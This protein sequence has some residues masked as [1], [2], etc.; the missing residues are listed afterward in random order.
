[1]GATMQGI[2]IGKRIPI[3]AIVGGLMGFG[4]SMWNATHPDAQIS[5]GDAAGLTTATIG[6][7]QLLVVNLFGVTNV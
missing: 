5:A 1:M 2:V 3:G 6:V 4:F 7:V